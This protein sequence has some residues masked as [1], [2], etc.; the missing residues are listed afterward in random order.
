MR[1][2]D[3]AGPL[4]MDSEGNVKP[5]AQDRIVTPLILLVLAGRP[6]DHDR[7]RHQ[8]GKDLVASNSLGFI[9]FIVGT[10]A[11]QA[12]LA[13]G[14]GYYGAAISLYDRIFARGKEVAFPRDTRVTIETTARKT[15][16]MR[17]DR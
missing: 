6:L 7:G 15:A 5:K 3:L 16:P 14:I 17:P 4:T 13:A 2:A 12:N 1:A 9:G 8:F 10:A 11:R